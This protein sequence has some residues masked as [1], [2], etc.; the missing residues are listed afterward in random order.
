[1]IGNEQK[2]KKKITLKFGD[3][4]VEVYFGDIFKAEKSDLK[5]I[6]FNEYFDTEVDGQPTL[7]SSNTING[8]FLMKYKDKIEE[9][10]SIIDKDQNLNSDMLTGTNSNR[11]YGKKNIYRLG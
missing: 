3:S 6:S 10:N 4:D 11:K 7:V 2:N 9:F 1:M 5:I 8:K